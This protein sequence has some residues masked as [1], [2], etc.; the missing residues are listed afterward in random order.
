MQKTSSKKT[1]ARNKRA[2]FDYDISEKY[3]AGVELF[4]YEVKSAKQ[5]LVSLRESFI[6]AEKGQVWLINAH[7]AQWKHASIK[8]YDPQRRR[9]LL[10]SKKEIK[11]LFVAQD[12]KKLSIVPLNMFVKGR[13]IKITL[14]VGKGRKKYDKRAKIKERE[15]KKDIKQEL[16]RVRKY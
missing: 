12:G 10:L 1:I 11:E 8:D 15:M 13:W 3:I 6:H 9:K 2:T 16:A 7:I 14:G 5:G 4:G